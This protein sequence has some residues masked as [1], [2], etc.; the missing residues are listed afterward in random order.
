MTLLT[1]VKTATGSSLEF[2]EGSP[3]ELLISET[4]DS[5]ALPSVD[6][7]AIK[8]MT[9]TEVYQKVAPGQSVP[10][11]LVAAD[12]RHA[13]FAAVKAP[14]TESPVVTSQIEGNTLGL[15]AVAS[16][17]HVV[18]KTFSA[19]YG[20]PNVFCTP[21]WFYNTFTNARVACDGPNVNND[22]DWERAS[23]CLY[24]TG[25]GSVQAQAWNIFN[26]WGATCNKSSSGPITL[27]LFRDR[28]SPT[29]T[30]SMSP[31][32]WRT[33][34]WLAGT[35]F[36]GNPNRYDLRWVITGTNAD[37]QFA[38]GVYW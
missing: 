17:R 34:G 1:S 21:Q 14:S 23:W 36:W 19:P 11:V 15:D 30:Y 32:V 2:Y 26:D 9:A 37:V 3:G 18:I 12:A 6:I 8:N 24:D 29:W 4:G 38:S 13:E 5:S 22:W 35:D 33:W 7:L 28:G 16:H 20:N 10:E 31:G 25:G 27:N